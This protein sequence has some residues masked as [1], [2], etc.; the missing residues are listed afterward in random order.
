ML[1]VLMEH[2]LVTLIFQQYM[3]FQNQEE[4]MIYHTMKMAKRK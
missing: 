2:H 3:K 1:N 4:L